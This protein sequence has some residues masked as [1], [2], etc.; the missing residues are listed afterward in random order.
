MITIGMLPGIDPERIEF[1]GNS[2]GAG[3]VMV[4][5]ENDYFTKCIEM[6]K[7]IT[8]IELVTEMSFQE[9]FVKNLSFSTDNFDLFPN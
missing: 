9:I 2:A 6:A 8:T 4:L 7:K 1:A 5:C 3:A